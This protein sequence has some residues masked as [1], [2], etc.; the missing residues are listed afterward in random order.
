MSIL[1]NGVA[2]LVAL[3]VATLVAHRETA[4]AK[5]SAAAKAEAAAETKAAAAVAGQ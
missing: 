3:R 2:A 5:A 4:A 1:G